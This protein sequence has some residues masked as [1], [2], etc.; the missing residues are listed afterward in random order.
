VLRQAVGGATAPDFRIV[1][2]PRLSPRAVVAKL[3]V[4]RGGGRHMSLLNQKAKQRY[5]GTEGQRYHEGKRAIPEVAFPWVARL[6]A[7]KIVPEVQSAD[8]VLEYGVG[9]GWSLAVVPCARK[10]GYD[11]GEFLAPVVRTRGIEWVADL[12]AVARDSVD[13]VVCHHTL[14][15]AAAPGEVLESIHG[16]LRP[17]GRLLLF[18]PYEK[19]RRFRQFDPA[20]PNHHL[21]SWNVQTLGNLVE[22]AGFRVRR[23]CLAPFGQERFAAIWAAR[24]RLGEGG[25]RALRWTANRLKQEYEVRVIAGKDAPGS[26][27]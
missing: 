24:L 17:G 27:R 5:Q 19:E 9:L 8:T 2:A 22:S 7:G 3:R 13:V 16:L 4:R 6:R 12:G 20:E 26:G 10:L 23:A 25:F 11:V 18:V 21:Y 15:H 14:E 1:A